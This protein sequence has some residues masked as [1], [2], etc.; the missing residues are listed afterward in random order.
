MC[1]RRGLSSTPQVLLP[2]DSRFETRLARL[3]AVLLPSP[4]PCRSATHTARFFGR[5][6]PL[7]CKSSF[8]NS[9][10]FPLRLCGFSTRLTALLGPIVKIAPSGPK[11]TAC[12]NEPCRLCSPLLAF[13]NFSLMHLRPVALNLHTLA[14]KTG[15]FA[16][17]AR[18]AHWRVR[19]AVSSERLIHFYT[20]SHAPSYC[21]QR[22][23]HLSPLSFLSLASTCFSSPSPSRAAAASALSL[24]KFS[25]N[26][27]QPL[28]MLSPPPTGGSPLLSGATGC[29]EEGGQGGKNNEGRQ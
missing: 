5:L 25:F 26:R 17:T 12:S 18:L 20:S 4:A 14:S 19:F 16:G 3:R 24:P 9:S 27:R 23:S 10:M 11:H 22:A 13:V 7:D 1:V 28:D 6:L 15:T 8:L 29:V 21:T 2:L